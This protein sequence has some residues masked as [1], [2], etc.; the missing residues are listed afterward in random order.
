MFKIQSWKTV[1]GNANYK[2][3]AQCSKRQCVVHCCERCS[4][5]YGDCAARR[6]QNTHTL[7][8]SQP[9]DTILQDSRF[10]IQDSIVYCRLSPIHQSQKCMYCRLNAKISE[11]ENSDS[12]I[13]F[14][15]LCELRATL[16]LINAPY[17]FF[18]N[19]W[20]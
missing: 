12:F 7:H 19:H 16:H 13:P 6:S 5:A 14:K 11:M 1:V 8:T 17:F 10:K 18:K 9:Q 20:P 3:K 2:K 15:A 4:R